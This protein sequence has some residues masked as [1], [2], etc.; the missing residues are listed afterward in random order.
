MSERLV[1]DLAIAED[2]Q[3]EIKYRPEHNN[4]SYVY[5]CALSDKG[6]NN[7]NVKLTVTYDMG[8]QKI[9]SGRK[10]DSYRGHALIIG[11]SRR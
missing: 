6:N 5:W 1:R 9:S 4:Q 7:N 3:Y 11:G 10:Y 8:W 2:I